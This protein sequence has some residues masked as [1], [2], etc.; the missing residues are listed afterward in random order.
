MK[1]F[2]N[3]IKYNGIKYLINLYSEEFKF[4]LVV[5]FLLV[6]GFFTALVSALL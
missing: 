6:V 4:V 5:S 2:Y 3:G 1:S